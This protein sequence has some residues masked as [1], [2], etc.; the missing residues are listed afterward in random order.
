MRYQTTSCPVGEHPDVDPEEGYMGAGYWEP[1]GAAYV[2]Q[3]YQSVGS[4]VV[5][6][7]R[8]QLKAPQPLQPLHDLDTDEVDDL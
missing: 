7:S 4:L 2:Q 6:W 1:I 5:V 8:A 3:P